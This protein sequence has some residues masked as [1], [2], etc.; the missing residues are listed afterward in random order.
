MTQRV[1]VHSKQSVD[2]YL[3]AKG[4]DKAVWLLLAEPGVGG[5]VVCGSASIPEGYRA[6]DV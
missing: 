2:C 3:E 1:G 4:P 6:K 5:T